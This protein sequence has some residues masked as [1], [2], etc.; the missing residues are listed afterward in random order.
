[1]KIYPA[2]DI[3]NGVCV[4]LKMGDLQ[5]ET[6]YGDP[7]GIAAEWERQGA[8]VIHIVDLDAAVTGTFSNRDTI[9]RILKTVKIPV[10]LGGGIRNI[11]DIDT[12][13]GELGIWRV[14]IGTAAIENPSLVSAAVRK[15]PSR[16]AV[17]IDAKN[18]KAATRGWTEG[19]SVTPVSLAL[20]MKKLGVNTIIYTDISRDGML[21]GPDI[22]GTSDMVK[23]TGMDIIASGGMCTMDDI[24]KV[25]ET[26]AEGVIIGKALY[27]GNIKLN[28]AIKTGA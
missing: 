24:I 4:R 1:M 3:K 27:S 7:A 13:L 10:Q 14:I 23:K 22:E 15:Y 16:V 19:T 6:Q 21:T 26:G 11:D 9:V 2:I 25:K 20:D 5:Q 17:G 28:E 18:G 12:R 8:E